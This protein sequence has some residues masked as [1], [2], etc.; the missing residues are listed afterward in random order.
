M[1]TRKLSAG[2]QVKERVTSKGISK[3]ASTQSSQGQVERGDEAAAQSPLGQCL[4]EW[5][6]WSCPQDSRIIKLSK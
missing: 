3:N 6:G 4:L 1:D 5:W 2:H